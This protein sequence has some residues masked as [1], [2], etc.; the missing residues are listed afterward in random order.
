V[1]DFLRGTRSDQSLIPQLTP[2]GAD[3]FNAAAADRPGVRYGCVVTRSRRPAIAA[4]LAGGLGA[5]AQAS[6]TVFEWLYALTSTFP[7]RAVPRLEVAQETALLRALDRPTGREDN[8]GIVPSLSQVWGE[9]V[10]AARADHLDVIGHFED[11][12]QVPPHHDWLMSGS[13]FD[14]A[15]FERLWDDVAAFIAETAR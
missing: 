8:D 15:G 7:S 13:G 5:Y 1:T 14:R 9:V 3:I 6:Y 12:R 11:P 2:E 10:H 4:R